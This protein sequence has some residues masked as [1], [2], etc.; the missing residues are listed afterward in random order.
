MISAWWLL[1]ALIIGAVVGVILFA[2]VA[3]RRDDDE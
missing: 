3:V 2:L 1:F